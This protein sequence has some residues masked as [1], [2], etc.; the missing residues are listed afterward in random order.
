MTNKKEVKKASNKIVYI[1]FL[2]GLVILLLIGFVYYQSQRPN[3]RDLEKAFNELQVPEGWQEVR[4]YSV[5]GYKGLFCFTAG[6]DESCPVLDRAFSNGQQAL[7]PTKD[8]EL[9]RSSLDETKFTITDINNENCRLDAEKYY[10]SIE[11]SDG[12]IGLIVAVG[13]SEGQKVIS[14]NLSR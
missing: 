6:L 4:R 8:M 9:V 14:F 3:Y 10:C 11:A 7:D 13:Y 12:D 1:F 5:T 2:V